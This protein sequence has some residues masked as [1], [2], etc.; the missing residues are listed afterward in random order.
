VT[1]IFSSEWDLVR[2]PP[3]P[4]NGPGQ[5]VAWAPTAADV[6]SNWRFTTTIATT[7]R[8]VEIWTRLAVLASIY[9]LLNSGREA[10]L[11]ADNFSVRANISGLL[12][13]QEEAV[14]HKA[15]VIVPT[16]DARISIIS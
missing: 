2:E 16:S 7:K 3:L 1:H 11:S 15:C 6:S 13:L 4:R 9:Q 14:D 5:I 12:A 10:I 8:I